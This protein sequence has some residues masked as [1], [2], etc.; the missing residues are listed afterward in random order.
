MCPK[1]KSI[2]T[3]IYN[4]RKNDNHG[5]SVWRRRICN[6]CCNVWT[7]IEVTQ[8][9]F[10]KINNQASISEKIIELEKTAST[11][12]EKVKNLHL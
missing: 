6:S 2:K 7:T 10:D 9:Y 5:G 3:G 4:T 1:C 12:I 11:I 8:E